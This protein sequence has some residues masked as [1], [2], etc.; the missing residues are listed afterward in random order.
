MR[1]EKITTTKKA[2]QEFIKTALNCAE[3]LQQTLQA[4]QDAT[5]SEIVNKIL[6][7][8]QA[9]LKAQQKTIAKLHKDV[10]NLKTKLAKK[11]NTHTII[12]LPS[13][14]IVTDND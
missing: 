11:S 13:K 14:V 7:S 2:V 8:K 10:Q 5:D 3:K 6:A 4:E 12:V 9:V 1:K